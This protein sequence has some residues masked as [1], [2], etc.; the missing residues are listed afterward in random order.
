MQ[1]DQQ[2]TIVAHRHEPFTGPLCECLEQWKL[3]SE[4]DQKTAL[5]SLTTSYRGWRVLEPKQILE[6]NRR[7]RAELD[8]MPRDR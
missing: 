6:L 7:Y 8:P 5:I 4:I 2:A 1:W 3:L